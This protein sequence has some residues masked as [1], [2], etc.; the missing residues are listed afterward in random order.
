MANSWERKLI[1]HCPVCSN[2]IEQTGSLDV[3]KC[4]ECG[5]VYAIH[6]EIKELEVKKLG[7]E[8]IRKQIIVGT[9]QG[10]S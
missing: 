5:R 6:I 9:N 1:F 8:N 7:Y 3:F 2:T 10:S 4:A